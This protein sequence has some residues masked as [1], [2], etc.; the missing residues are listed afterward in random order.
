MASK[1]RPPHPCALAPYVQD[2]SLIGLDVPRHPSFA[3][4]SKA[5]WDVVGRIL[6]E[7]MS[8]LRI[9]EAGC[10]SGVFA[11]LCAMRNAKVV[12]IDVVDRYLEQAEAIAAHLDDVA[13]E[14]EFKKLSVYEAD[15]LGEF[16]IVLALGLLYHLKFWIYA[17][18]KLASV[19]GK[20]L[21]IDTELLSEAEDAR[22][23]RFVPTTYRDDETNWWI[24]GA[25]LILDRLE[26]LGFSSVRA[27]KVGGT[28]GD[29]HYT[30]GIDPKTLIPY[31]RRGIFVAVRDGIEP[32]SVL[33]TE[34]LDAL[35]PLPVGGEG[36]PVELARKRLPMWILSE[37][38]GPALRISNAA[39]F[40]AVESFGRARAVAEENGKL[41]VSEPLGE[42]GSISIRALWYPRLLWQM[43]ASIKP[44]VS[45]SPDSGDAIELDVAF[46][47]PMP[48]GT[49]LIL[50]LMCSRRDSWRVLES[51]AYYAG[52][53]DALTLS[54]AGVS[55][56]SWDV[57]LELMVGVP[58]RKP[59]RRRFK[60]FDAALEHPACPLIGIEARPAKVEG[61]RTGGPISP[62]KFA[63]GDRVLVN[64]GDAGGPV[65]LIWLD[66]ELVPFGI[67]QIEDAR[68][69]FEVDTMW[70]PLGR[71]FVLIN[72]ARGGKREFVASAPFLCEQGETPWSPDISDMPHAG[73]T[74]KRIISPARIGSGRRLKIAVEY[75][76][77]PQD[78]WPMIRVSLYRGAYDLVCEWDSW[79]GGLHLHASGGHFIFDCPKLPLVPG[80]YELLLSAHHPSR[81]TL[82]TSDRLPLVVEEPDE[83]G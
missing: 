67:T 20:L 15:K 33:R 25:G 58:H 82:A 2:L 80:D 7:D 8:G 24:P 79:S 52:G 47:Q 37:G 1:G 19:A 9:L 73:F 31:G 16:D 51:T 59:Y 23:A 55:P 64:P 63:R 74:F 45:L 32:E 62:D 40:R 69:A 41:A 49:Y 27:F 44:E 11:F 36:A 28:Y 56:A 42:D 6:P 53:K 83:R 61:G 39:E 46:P 17:L 30:G 14:V 21:V 38:L 71:G 22:Q 3:T 29:E 10:N 65:E 76:F 68:G 34:A 5:V 72:R 78:I 12:G 26:A 18:N 4:D 75:E 81:G 43:P 48:P 70:F 54:I 66:A 35:E 77:F 50:N 57:W 13:G 60:L